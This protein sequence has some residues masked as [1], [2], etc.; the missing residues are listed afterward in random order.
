ML[1]IEALTQMS[2]LSILTLPGNKGE[3]M[4]LVSAEKLLFKKKVLPKKRFVIKTEVIKYQRGLVSCNA[5]GFVDNENVC[6]AKLNLAL[7]KEIKKY[8]IT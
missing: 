8:S 6:S 4:Y 5:M 7:P 2:A 1:Q 3:I